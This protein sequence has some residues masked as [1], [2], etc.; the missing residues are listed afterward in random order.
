[1]IAGL[2][3]HVPFGIGTNQALVH[4]GREVGVLVV[5]WSAHLHLLALLLLVAL[6]QGFAQ[7]GIG[8][9]VQRRLAFLVLDCEVGA[10]AGQEAGYACRR[11][12]VGTLGSQAHQELADV[13]DVLEL[14]E[15]GE[16]VVSECLVEWSVAVFV[17]YVEVGAFPNQQ[18]QNQEKTKLIAIHVSLWHKATPVVSNNPTE[19]KSF[20]WNILLRAHFR[21]PSGTI[22]L[23]DG[24]LGSISEMSFLDTELLDIVALITHKERYYNG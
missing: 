7:V 17:G 4:G 3:Q 22:R 21:C 11:L 2:E 24:F 1:M 16:G 20:L 12:L 9:E 10:V 18:L 13:L 5:R 6:G 8:A 14:A 19:S 23:L 15:L